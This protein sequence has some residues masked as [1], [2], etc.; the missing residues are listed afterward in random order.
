MLKGFVDCRG[1]LISI[2]KEDVSDSI[3]RRQSYTSDD[4]GFLLF[5]IERKN[6]GAA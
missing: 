6:R 5:V 4:T 2:L 3:Q 1:G